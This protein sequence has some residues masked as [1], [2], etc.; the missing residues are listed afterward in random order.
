[1]RTYRQVQDFE[2]K[3]AAFLATHRDRLAATE[4]PRGLWVCE[5]DGE[6]Y[7]VLLV[8][9]DPHIRVSVIVDKPEDKPFAALTKLAEAFE[10]WALEAGVT[11]YGVVVHV[12]DDHYCKIIERRGGVEVGVKDGWV[13]YLHTINAQLDT[14]DG[15]RAWAPADWRPL[16]PLMHAFLKEHRQAGGDFLPTRRNVETF[17][18]R[19]MKAATTKG[20]PCVIAWDG[21]QPVGFAL[22]LGI[23]TDLDVAHRVVQ[24]V[25]TY[26]V[27]E[28]RR[29]GW[30]K[31]IRQA[32]MSV[33][34]ERGYTQV[35][36]TAM[37]KRGMAA[38]KSVGGEVHGVY[39]RLDLTKEAA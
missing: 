25:G 30:S 28:K 26:V 35:A 39:M 21:G 19:G 36:G 6:P 12:S 17:I 14:S 38:G 31:R 20:D 23:D 3:V 32:A 10:A 8:Y 22:W 18:R 13:E 34:R 16:R 29:A 9:T 37:D 7:I 1:M 15:I 2:P 33:A 11:T 4:P 5:Q 27:P 24:G